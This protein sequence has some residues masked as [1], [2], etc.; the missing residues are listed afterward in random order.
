[1]QAASLISRVTAVYI[2]LSTSTLTLV[3]I[4]FYLTTLKPTLV[5]NTLLLDDEDDNNNNNNN[6]NDDDD[7]NN[8]NNNINDNDDDDDDLSRI[9]RL[10]PDLE[11]DRSSQSERSPAAAPL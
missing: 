10:S 2:S 4:L 8:N 1:M 6:N 11:R 3:N 5:T 7:V 9:P